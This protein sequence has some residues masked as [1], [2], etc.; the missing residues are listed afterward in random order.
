MY[1]VVMV[2]AL[3]RANAG[4]RTTRSFGMRRISPMRASKG[5]AR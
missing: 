1:V 4:P 3:T 5:K 2:V